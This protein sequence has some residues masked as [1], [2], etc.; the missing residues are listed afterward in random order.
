MLLWGRMR[1]YHLLLIPVVYALC[2]APA[3][4]FGRT[5]LEVFTAYTGQADSGQALTHN[6]AT[7]YAFVPKAAY[8]WLF[9]PAVVGA[10]AIFG[11]WVFAHVAHIPPEG[12]PRPRAH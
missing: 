10:I 1:W 2:M 8:S 12:G 9:W 4:A 5:W 3:V 11:T 6:G 7:L